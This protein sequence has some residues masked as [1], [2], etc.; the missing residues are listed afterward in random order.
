MKFYSQL[1]KISLNKQR[2]KGR[3]STA[4]WLPPLISERDDFIQTVALALTSSK[5]RMTTI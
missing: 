5:T 2:W 3:D 1:K 4:Q